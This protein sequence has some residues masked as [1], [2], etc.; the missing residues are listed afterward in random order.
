MRR[1]DD[2][3]DQNLKIYQD[4]NYPCFSEDSILL[5]HFSRFKQEDRVI[6]LG[7]GTGILSILGQ[8]CYGSTFTG[9]ESQEE[10]VALSQS[11]AERNGQNITFCHMDVRDAPDLLG[12][13][14][15]SAAIC[16]PPY[17]FHGDLPPDFSRSMS[18]HGSED[19]LD[20]FFQAAFQL[21][22]NRGLF[23]LCFPANGL[24]LV[25]DRLMRNRMTPKRLQLVSAREG[26][27]P[28]LALIEARKLSN[29]GLIVEPNLILNSK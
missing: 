18:R 7:S 16:N 12:R 1:L 13:G 11:S 3:D 10:L 23:F 14:M 15:F 9:I 5:L 4:S 20:L 2:L 22:K 25:F 8:A 27:R 29:S 6:D 28:Y 24:A 26:K 21:L 17:Y 19:L